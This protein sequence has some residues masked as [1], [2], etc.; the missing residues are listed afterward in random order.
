MTQAFKISTITK[1]L[2]LILMTL[3]LNIGWNRALHSTIRG[4]Q[5][6][7]EE[8]CS[9]IPVK[10]NIVNKN[11]E[12]FPSLGRRVIV[13][14]LNVIGPYILN[15]FIRRFEQPFTE[16]V[17]S[18]NTKLQEECADPS[19]HV[20]FSQILKVNLLN[21]LPEILFRSTPKHFG[22]LHLALFF[23]WGRYYELAKRLASVTYKYELG[24]EGQHGITYLKPGRVIMFAMIVQAIALGVSV[25]KAVFATHKTYQKTKY[26]KTLLRE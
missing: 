26:R 21:L 18:K 17:I 19:I 16:Y 3:L 4:K 25:G 1:T 6:L 20:T 10:S 14:L 2:L 5:T 24:L 22:Q 9:I 12:A 7:G 13:S 23:I 8:Y 15:K 11:K